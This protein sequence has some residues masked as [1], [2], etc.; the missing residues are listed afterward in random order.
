MNTRFDRLKSKLAGRMPVAESPKVDWLAVAQALQKR[1][2][3]GVKVPH[4]PL[5]RTGRPEDL[6]G[7]NLR[8]QR[9]GWQK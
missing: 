1:L 5:F 3:T 4:I 8:Q 2:Y 7:P 9:K 6:Q